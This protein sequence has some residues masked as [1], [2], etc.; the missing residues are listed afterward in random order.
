MSKNP[1]GALAQSPCQ[2]VICG[3]QLSLVQYSTVLYYIALSVGLQQPAQHRGAT[4]PKA[5]EKKLGL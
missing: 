1:L 4:L 5:R 2:P 3:I